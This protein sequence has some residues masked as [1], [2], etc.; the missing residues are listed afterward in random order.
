MVLILPLLHDHLLVCKSRDPEM[1]D[2]TNLPIG[3]DEASYRAWYA[4]KRK[5]DNRYCTRWYRARCA[6]LDGQV[7]DASTSTEGDLLH[8]QSGPVRVARLS[9]ELGK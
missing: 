8:L 6:S 1:A 3:N 4:E 2:R 7:E 9:Q 5:A